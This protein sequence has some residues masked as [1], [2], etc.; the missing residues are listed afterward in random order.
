MSR[1]SWRWRN[2]TIDQL[3]HAPEEVS[4]EALATLHR[5]TP[6]CRVYPDSAPKVMCYLE[7]QPLLPAA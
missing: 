7:W 4:Q 2:Q 1:R 5:C 3:L 6:C